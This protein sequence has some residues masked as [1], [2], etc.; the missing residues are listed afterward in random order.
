MVNVPPP[1]AR[2][3]RRERADERK[4]ERLIAEALLAAREIDQAQ[5]TIEDAAGR[6]RAAVCALRDGGMSVR[7]IAEA[8]GVTGPV[9]QRLLAE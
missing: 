6:R 8:L 5:R 3:P 2:G 7:A 9:V 1:G 4:L